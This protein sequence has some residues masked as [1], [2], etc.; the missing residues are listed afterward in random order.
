M[1]ITKIHS[2]LD[3]KSHTI[4]KL[5]VYCLLAFLSACSTPPQVTESRAQQTE[6]IVEQLLTR[7]ETATPEAAT[8][9]RLQASRALLNQERHDESLRI[10][11]L[12]TPEQ[13][14][15][16]STKADYLLLKSI[17]MV[18]LEL[19]TALSWLEQMSSDHLA[20]LTPQDQWL[21]HLAYATELNRHQRTNEAITLLEY[22]RPLMSE[23][24]ANELSEFIWQM[25]Q[26]KPSQELAEQLNSESNEVSTAWLK[27]ALIL[28]GETADRFK[29][30]ALSQ[31]L[32][33]YPDHP[34]SNKL[35]ESA[36]NLPSS[37]FS[38]LEKIAVILPLQGKFAR[39][40]KAIS[41]GFLMAAYQ[42]D[43]DTRPEIEII[44]SL[45]GDFL[46]KYSSIQADLI[47]GPLSPKHIEQL[48]QLPSLTIP[49]IA[50][51]S[52]ETEA[53]PANLFYMNLQAED[54]ARTMANYAAQQG[55]D[56]GAILTY[57]SN[58]GQKLAQTFTSA[59][60]QHD[61]S[62]AITQGYETNWATSLK[63]LLEIDKSDQRARNLSRLLRSPIEFTA[64]RRE[65]I[66]FIYSP[67]K[68][69]D[70]RQT[71]PLMAFY[72]A[73]D[74]EILSNS[75]ISPQLYSGK[76]DKDLNGVVFA[77]F[78]WTPQKHGVSSLPTKAE[79]SAKLFSWGA[80]AFKVAVQLPELITMQ[81]QAVKAYGAD[82]YFDGK[83]NFVREFPISY[84]RYG[85]P[86]EK[87]APDVEIN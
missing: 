43:E 58:K 47:I 22:Q 3:F 41:Q 37:E 19:D 30:L 52:I 63:K 48:E 82:V 73:D 40:S 72:F 31:W 32:N 84:V 18:Q 56:K 77:D 38:Q 76:Q 1:D 20:L 83:S 61:G 50:L 81:G 70:L 17:N 65:D 11:N 49:T 25:I 45:D 51:N 34:A 39:V 36:L 54:E 7:A 44:D 27:L 33:H 9:L 24:E 53:P 79:A 14:I 15:T 26:E 78:H 6:N 86:Y 16:D 69:K 71:N 28:N 87:V 62:I 5:P 23:K 35:P 13:L 55:H 85:K 64:R 46:T 80:D 66:Q 4:S 67:L 29:A 60:E 59:F 2:F 21:W 8:E 68:Y 57:N 75:D 12:I 42:L 10:L 74:I